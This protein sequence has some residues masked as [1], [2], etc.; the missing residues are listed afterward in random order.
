MAHEVEARETE[1]EV[2]LVGSA[3]DQAAQVISTSA[4]T[5]EIFYVF[6][7]DATAGLLTIEVSHDT[8]VG[9]PFIKLT[10]DAVMV[11][12]ENDT[13]PIVRAISSEG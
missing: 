9:G 8:L 5:Q 2:A 11:G 12:G 1:I 7:T 6:N 10:D 4:Q 13:I 3:T